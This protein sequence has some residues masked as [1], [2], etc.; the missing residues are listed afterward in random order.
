MVQMSGSSPR[1]VSINPSECWQRSCRRCVSSRR[2]FVCCLSGLSV[3]GCLQE[4]RYGCL[5]GVREKRS[6]VEKV[7]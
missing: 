2:Y 5:R 7:W 3:T 6:S 1:V 4:I